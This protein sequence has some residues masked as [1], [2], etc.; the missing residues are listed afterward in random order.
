MRGKPDRTADSEIPTL[1]INCHA[2]QIGDSGEQVQ[3][4]L[5]FHGVVHGL[6]YGGAAILRT[7]GVGA[8]PDWINHSAT[9]LSTYVIKQA[10][11]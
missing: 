1:Q 2:A 8:V 7:R 5:Q 9:A 6:G 10:N 3:P 11:I 4:I